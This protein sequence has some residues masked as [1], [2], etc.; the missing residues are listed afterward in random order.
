MREKNFK[1]KSL[2]DE[3]KSKNFENTIKKEVGKIKQNYL[4]EL[5]Q[6]EEQQYK[7]K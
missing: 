6:I 4:F 2:E 5:K 7:Q 1:I 3:L